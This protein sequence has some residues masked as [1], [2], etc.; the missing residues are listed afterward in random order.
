MKLT[1]GS[2][3]YLGQKTQK[4][5]MGGPHLQKEPHYYLMI[6]D[7]PKQPLPLHY[8]V[9]Q[10]ILYPPEE[11]QLQQTSQQVDDLHCITVVQ[12][13]E[14]LKGIDYLVPCQ[15]KHLCK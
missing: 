7:N 10:Q 6:K 5:Q 12:L 9:L 11:S 2:L 15:H 4:H 14:Q 3:K 1:F 8:S 13:C